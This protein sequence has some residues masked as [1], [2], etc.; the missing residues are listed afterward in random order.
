MDSETWAAI[1]AVAASVAVVIAFVA[2]LYTRRA[3]NAAK[4][5]TELQERAVKAA[6]AQTDLQREVAQDAVQPYVWVDVLPDEAQGTLLHLVLGNS[7]PTFAH[8]A[9]VTIEPPLP[10]SL[11]SGAVDGQRRLRE[12]I[13][14]LGPGRRL[15]WALGV[16]YEVVEEDVPKL[17]TITIDVEGPFGPLPQRVYEINLTD[18]RET[19]DAPEGN[20]H[21]VR[22]AIEKVAN[23]L[24]RRN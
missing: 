9:R 3:A 15:A 20:L 10:Q 2:L 16:G 22:K 14:A 4:A 6:I 1:A 11:P 7:G 23:N 24:G 13:K 21:F 17:H 18:L 12:G 8:N 5:Q 19:H